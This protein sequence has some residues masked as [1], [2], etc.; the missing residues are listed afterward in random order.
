[1]AQLHVLEEKQPLRHGDISIGLE[2][3]H[4]N[5]LARKHV[6]DHEFGQDI[7][8]DPGYD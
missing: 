3:H 6:T 7:E 2:E 1:M 8:S 4:S 5:R